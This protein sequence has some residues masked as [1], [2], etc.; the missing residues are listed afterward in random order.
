MTIP[1]HNLLRTLKD[2][3]NQL[4]QQNRDLRWELNHLRKVIARMN[5]WDWDLSLLESQ[6]ELQEITGVILNTALFSVSSS[7]GSILLLDEEKEDLVFMSVIGESKTAL[8]D[9][10]IPAKE[11]IAGWV[12]KKRKPALVPNVK[13]DDRWLPAVDQSIGFHTKCL[14][15]V[16]LQLGDR[17]F[18]VME[19][20]NSNTEE[21]FD[22][23][24]L[25]VLHLVG[26][27]CSYLLAFLEES[28]QPPD[29]S[30]LTSFFPFSST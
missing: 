27:F 29:R 24:D 15:A 5:A 21:P 17:V 1:D 6:Q 22:G 9:Y 12:V 3:H 13:H 25:D 19:V 23:N 8:V 16:P 10:R 14:M 18:G 7:N 26:N 20:V 28:G 11:G 4:K 30:A 2:E